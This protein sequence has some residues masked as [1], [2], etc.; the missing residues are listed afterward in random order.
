[1]YFE[2]DSIITQPFCIKTSDRLGAMLENIV[3]H[4]LL[5]V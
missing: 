4:M 1:M 5:A 3:D 2:K